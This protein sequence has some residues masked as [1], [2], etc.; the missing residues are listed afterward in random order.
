MTPP[1]PCAAPQQFSHEASTKEKNIEKGL[2]R[3]H[4]A[5][6]RMCEMKVSEGI[7]PMQQE[8][9]RKYR[10][11]NC[12]E[13]VTKVTSYIRQ[14]V[15]LL[16]AR[17]RRGLRLYTGAGT[18]PTMEHNGSKNNREQEWEGPPVPSPQLTLLRPT[19]PH[20]AGRPHVEVSDGS[21]CGANCISETTH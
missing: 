6:K 19:P 13:S 10:C 16:R 17:A 21:L 18:K 14:Q 3:S 15:A 11:D 12:H 2:I 1:Q 20:N 5:P 7:A 4:S 9:R 8:T